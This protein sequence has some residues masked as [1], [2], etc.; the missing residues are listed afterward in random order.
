LGQRLLLL[1]GAGGRALVRLGRA[2]GIGALPAVDIGLVDDA[3]QPTRAPNDGVARGAELLGD[4]GG[5]QSLRLQG[6]QTL[7]AR[8]RPHR[9]PRWHLLLPTIGRKRIAAPIQPTG[10]H[11]APPV[12]DL[13]TSMIFSEG[14]SPPFGSCSA[15]P[16]SPQANRSRYCMF[17]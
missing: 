3:A 14:P 15:R 13:G 2:P 11:P 9:F 7:V 16:T 4:L 17:F 12:T 8:R 10:A 6:L 1:V 5:A